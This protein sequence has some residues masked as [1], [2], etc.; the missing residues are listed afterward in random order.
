MSL[1]NTI[2]QLVPRLIV[3]IM[4][5]GAGYFA[6]SAA[7]ENGLAFAGVYA[8]VGFAS[9]AI[10]CW[11]L[12]AVARTTDTATAAILYTICIFGTG[13]VV[14][15]GMRFTATHITENVGASAD[16]MSIYEQA[17]RD[18]KQA[19]SELKLAQANDTW[20]KT[21]A[22]T[23]GSLL[24][25]SEAFCNNVKVI[26][27]NISKAKDGM[28]GG[29]PKS[30]D[31][32]GEMLASLTGMSLAQ[33]NFWWQIISS[34]AMDLFA[35]GCMTAAF[36]PL[37]GG[38][39]P[40]QTTEVAAQPTQEPTASTDLPAQLVNEL[41]SFQLMLDLAGA[42]PPGWLS[43]TPMPATLPKLAGPF[44]FNVDKRSMRTDHWQ[45]KAANE[46]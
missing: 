27:T 21:S 31:P 40:I 13:Y 30:A 7:Y 44:R 23:A 12:P 42:A 1:L 24:P 45:Q 25:K 35:T 16:R 6:A 8:G 29:K 38:S 33:A 19:E 20:G 3:G 9:I 32:G 41:L 2:F 26:K 15:N 28:K 4:G 39:K 14:L 36:A 11:F 46:R 43:D 18:L 17:E 22:C 5:I 10:A 37:R 34:L